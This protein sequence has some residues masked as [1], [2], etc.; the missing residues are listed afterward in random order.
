MAKHL[1]CKN[2]VYYRHRGLEDETNYIG[3]CEWIN[4]EV[5]EE[6]DACEDFEEG[7]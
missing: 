7:E 6:Q 2:C 1:K 3:L 5:G 4:E